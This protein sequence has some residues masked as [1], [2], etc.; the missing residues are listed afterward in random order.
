LDGIRVVDATAWFAGPVTGQL[1]AAL[2]AEVI[3]LESHV[4]LE[5][6]RTVRGGVA[7]DRWWERGF[8]FHQANT[9]KLSLAVDLTR[10]EGRAAVRRVIAGCDLVV[11]NFSPRV[12][13]TFGL[14]WDE[15][16]ALNPRVSLVRLPAFGLDGP[17][18]DRVGFGETMEQCTG[19]AWVTGFPDAPPRQPAGPCD[20]LAG[21][22]GAFGALLALEQ[23]DRTG[24]G[25]LIEVAMAETVLNAAAE[26]LVEY[27]AYGR[28][29][30]RDGNRTGAAAPQGLYRCRGFENWLAL[31]VTD[32][33]DW[34]ALKAVLGDP[35]WADDP[36]YDEL[37][38]RRA[39][40]DDIDRALA[41]WAAGQDLDDVVEE[42]VAR[43]VP[44]GRAVD[45]RL[46]Y[47]RP[48]FQARGVYEE[49]EHPVAGT[50]AVAAIPFRMT[51]VE[52]WWARP[53]PMLGQHNHQV[54]RDIAGLDDEAIR[55]LEDAGVIGTQPIG[56]GAISE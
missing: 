37:E 33:A 53:A 40:H 41:A 21:S 18:R 1:L 27:S 36:R 45:P 50:V 28:L 13:D 3:H 23:R 8:L 38:G 12:F 6:G 46:G 5:G 43:G 51:G 19:M 55:A 47:E 39:G 31:T 4:R 30:E 17:W 25:A 22:H 48:Q 2:G 56:V 11:E 49:V 9:G 26:P 32:D 44:A 20:P 42:L 29:M 54:L 35:A 34:N 10:E 16:R 14:G 52:R 24:A 15:L 7:D